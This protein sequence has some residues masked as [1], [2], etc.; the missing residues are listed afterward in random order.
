MRNLIFSSVSSTRLARHNSL[1]SPAFVAPAASRRSPRSNGF[2]VL[3][4]LIALV[5]LLIGGLAILNLF[6]PALN[7]IR[8]KRKP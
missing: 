6:P 2:T 8:G 4:V 5:V 7:V 1:R 3:E